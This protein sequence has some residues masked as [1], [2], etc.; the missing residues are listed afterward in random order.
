MSR[1]LRR[2]A[3]R[4]PYLRDLHAYVV[5][6]E[7]ER[8]AL[9]GELARMKT[10]VPPGH[11]YSPIPSTDEVRARETEI[12]AAPP[13]LPAIELN[14]AAQLALLESLERYYADVPFPRTQSV[15]TRY[16]YEN[17]A[18]S[19]GDAI[20]LY[21]MLREHRPRR[22][23]EIGSGF[24]SAVMLDT[25]ERFGLDFSLTCIEPDPATLRALL[26]PGDEV[27]LLDVPVQSV[28]LARFDLLGAGDVLF[29]D[30]THVSKTGSD[31]NRIVFEILPRLAAGVLVHFHDMF[32]PFEYPKEW[33][34][35]GRAWNE[36]YLLRAFLA[37]NGAFE[38]VLFTTF[39]AQFHRETLAR[40]MPLAMENPGGAL[41]LRRAG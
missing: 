9:R 3:R 2:L 24:S 32:Y 35:E 26:R 14:A 41:W 5:A 21:A 10:W 8:D 13:S 40:A 12:F 6:L 23:I 17:W 20:L 7:G 30:S 11:F 34:Y 31:V 28:P 19:Y 16:W 1:F 25:R 15:E 4:L 33:V 29:V 39:L 37:Y 36:D 18:Y 27:E 22:V 38:I